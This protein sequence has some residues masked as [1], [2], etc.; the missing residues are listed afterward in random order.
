MGRI[1]EQGEM[2]RKER[3]IKSKIQNLK[4]KILGGEEGIFYIR[5]SLPRA[6]GEPVKV[7]CGEQVMIIIISVRM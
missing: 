6:P 2:G 3:E 4:S 5:S 7:R 1:G